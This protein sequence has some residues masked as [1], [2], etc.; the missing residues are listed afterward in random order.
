MEDDDMNRIAITAPTGSDEPSPALA[1]AAVMSN[2]RPLEAKSATVSDRKNGAGTAAGIIGLTALVL[3]CA[4]SV[5]L[6]TITNPLDGGSSGA[7]GAPSAFGWCL[8][9]GSW[10]LASE[11]SVRSGARRAAALQGVWPSLAW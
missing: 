5:Q 3:L 11:T 2:P 10:P 4:E 1:E 6:F 8:F 9:S 7:S